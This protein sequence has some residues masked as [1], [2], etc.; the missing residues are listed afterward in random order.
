MHQI[1]LD[2]APACE[3]GTEYRDPIS[4][5]QG[6]AVALT[7]WQFGCMRVALQP[8]VDKDGKYV[9]T[10]TFDDPQLVAVSKQR[11]AGK[12]A[13]QQAVAI[14][15]PREMECELGMEYSD[16]VSGFQGVAVAYTIWPTVVRVTLQ[17]RVD[18]DGKNVGSWVFDDTQL[19]AVAKKKAL[20]EPLRREPARRSHGGRD[21]AAA[22][23]R[24]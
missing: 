11:K 19:V 3:I 16:P 21:E 18:K 20:A 14:L 22:L 15:L 1:N 9:D 8:R 13:S 23:R 4:G 17:P 5:F 10:Q 7:V 24:D 6:V 2:P 12:Q